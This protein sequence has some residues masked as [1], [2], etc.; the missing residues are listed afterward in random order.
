MEEIAAESVW[1]IAAAV[2]DIFAKALG[3]HCPID[4]WRHTSSKMKKIEDNSKF[5]ECFYL[6]SQFHWK[7]L[8]RE[9]KNIPYIT[10]T[11]W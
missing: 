10:D 8:Q 3:K 4:V 7:N 2:Q 9:N 1:R 5:V 6:I 11:G